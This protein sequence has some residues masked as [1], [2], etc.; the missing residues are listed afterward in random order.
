MAEANGSGRHTFNL[1]SAQIGLREILI[2]GF[3]VAGVLWTCASKWTHQTEA[4]DAL[5]KNV[6]DMATTV[7]KLTNDVGLLTVA[8]ADLTQGNANLNR[9]ITD[10]GK[11]RDAQMEILGNKISDLGDQ[12]ATLSRQQSTDHDESIDRFRAIGL[13]VANI[14]KDVATLKCRVTPKQCA[15]TP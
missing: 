2:A 9:T 10:R 1:M 12:F 4:V 13:Q 7:T 6:G 3:I 15:S 5:S 14:V 11:T 8:V